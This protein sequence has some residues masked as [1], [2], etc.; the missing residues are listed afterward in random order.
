LK[1]K[2]KNKLLEDEDL[3]EMERELEEEIQQMFQLKIAS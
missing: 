1:T 3:L 2:L